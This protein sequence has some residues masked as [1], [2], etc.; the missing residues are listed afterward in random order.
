MERTYEICYKKNGLI[1]YA[2]AEGI[3]N[4]IQVLTNMFNNKEIEEIIHVK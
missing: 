1:F 3:E 4:L 2:A